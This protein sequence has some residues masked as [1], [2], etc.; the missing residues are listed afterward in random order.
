V[1]ESGNGTRLLEAG[2]PR[3]WPFAQYP[4]P[5][6]FVGNETPYQNP[7]PLHGPPQ[8]HIV[9]FARGHPLPSKRDETPGSGDL[10]GG[11]AGHTIPEMAEDPLSVNVE[12]EEG[13]STG[14]AMT[15]Q[16]WIEPVKRPDGR[17]LVH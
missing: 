3:M 8:T 7:V 2:G 11:A 17:R 14:H 5:A 6:G 16:I 10:K 4:T 9:G 12:R 1:D 15:T 13:P